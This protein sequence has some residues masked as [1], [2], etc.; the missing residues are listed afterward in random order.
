MT[1]EAREARVRTFLKDIELT[2]TFYDFAPDLHH[3]IR[4]TNHLERLFRE[5][6]TKSDEIG[7]F[8]NETSGL[9]VFCLVVERDHASSRW[10]SLC[11]SRKR[12]RMEI[13]NC[14]S[15][16]SKPNAS[17]LRS[18]THP[19]Q[20]ASAKTRVADTHR[21]FAPSASRHRS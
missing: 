7:A 18:L 6:R 5:F 12:L 20:T 15:R 2:F 11:L 17:N 10:R 9:T 4:T 3:H 16:S 8:P 1:I 14:P 21:I 13:F 19:P